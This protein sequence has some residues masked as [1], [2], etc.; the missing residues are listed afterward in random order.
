VGYT[1]TIKVQAAE[2]YQSI[3]YNVTESFNYL[4]KTGTVHINVIGW[5]PLLRVCFNN[6]IYTTGTNG[7][8]LG[9]PAQ[10]NCVVSNGV[11]TG[12]SIINAGQG[13]LAPPLITFVGEGAGAEA[14]STVANGQ[15]TG[16]QIISGGSGYRPVPPTNIGAQVIISTGYVTDLS[17]R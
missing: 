17:Y 10:A 4:N 6:S 1:G 11:V 14:V 15:I 12:V 9:Y 8:V 13:Y 5:H 7:Q 2:N 16:I 3:F